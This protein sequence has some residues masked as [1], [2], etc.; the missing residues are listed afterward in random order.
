[1]N[2]YVSNLNFKLQDEDLRNVFAGFGEVA[3]AK[4]IRDNQSGRSRGF[5]FVEMANDDA[6]RAAIEQLNGKEVEGRT[7]VVNEARPKKEGGEGSDDGFKRHDNDNFDR[8]KKRDFN[9]D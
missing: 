3:S 4:V 7:I 5:G 8:R 6:A 9:R 1:M 2:I